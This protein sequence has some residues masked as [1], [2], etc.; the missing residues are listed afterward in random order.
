ME[1]TGLRPGSTVLQPK[2]SQK[3]R[4]VCLGLN[5][6]S[7]IVHQPGL[8]Y[9]VNIGGSCSKKSKPKNADSMKTRNLS[10]KP[11][12]S[13]SLAS[14]L[15]AG[16]QNPDPRSTSGR[17]IAATGADRAFGYARCELTV[18]LPQ[19][20]QKIMN[21]AFSRDA[22]KPSIA[23]LIARQLSTEPVHPDYLE[24]APDDWFVRKSLTVRFRVDRP[25]HNV[26]ELVNPIQFTARFDPTIPIFIETGDPGPGGW[27]C[28][29]CQAQP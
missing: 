16:Q 23:E 17:D 1:Q 26:L 9:Q 27:G 22:S 6:L 15:A 2:L 29:V 21:V 4:V 10:S 5:S 12:A 13:P 20:Q 25:D 11:I 8:V 7:R 14:R 3:K 18:I 28:I 19:K 24:M